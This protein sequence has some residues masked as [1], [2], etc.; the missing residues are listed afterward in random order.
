M[1]S[2]PISCRESRAVGLGSGGAA[3]RAAKPSGLVTGFQPWEQYRSWEEVGNVSTEHSWDK[4]IKNLS[5]G[6]SCTQ[7]T[8]PLSTRKG[9]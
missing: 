6:R 8:A 5:L 4:Q 3:E 2:L 1:K 9:R 7:D